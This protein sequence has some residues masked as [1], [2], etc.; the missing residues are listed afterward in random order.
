M[1]FDR[2]EILYWA[3]R[4][5][6]DYDREVETE[7]APKVKKR[8]YFIKSDLQIICAWKTHR[9]KSRV[10]SNL[11]DFIQAVTQTALSTSDERLRIEVLTLLAGVSW[12]TASV[13]L[14]FGHS[15][16]YPILDF[17]ALWSLSV[18]ASKI[19]YDFKFWWKYTQYCRGLADKAGVSMRTLD[20][21]LWQYSK[22]N[23]KEIS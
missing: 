9:S 11:E 1:R 5:P 18:D 14:H 16:P 12:P 19:D 4:Y 10:A 22:E 21:A 20:R 8:G 6:D 3:S 2:R 15:D 17:R 13:L 23:Q 7:V